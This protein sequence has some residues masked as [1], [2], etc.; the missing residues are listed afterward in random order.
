M[1]VFGGSNVRKV[2]ICSALQWHETLCPQTTNSAVTSTIPTVLTIIPTLLCTT[3][4]YSKSPLH[5]KV[6]TTTP[7]EQ[8]SVPVLQPTTSFHKVRV[9]HYSLLLH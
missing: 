4:Y 3:T 7:V 9:K 5:Y 6:Q 8:S 1:K 2:I